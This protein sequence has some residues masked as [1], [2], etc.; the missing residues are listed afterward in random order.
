MMDKI[1]IEKNI[2]DL[3]KKIMDVWAK[4]HENNIY[5]HDIQFVIREIKDADQ[6]VSD[7][8][9]L[10]NH[11]IYVDSIVLVDKIDSIQSEITWVDMQLCKVTKTNVLFLVKLIFG[12]DDEQEIKFHGGLMNILPLSLSEIKQ[13]M[14]EETQKVLSMGRVMCP[15]HISNNVSYLKLKLKQFA[16]QDSP[17][18]RERKRYDVFCKKKYE[19]IDDLAK[20]IYKYRNTLSW[21]DLLLYYT[22]EIETIIIVE[23]LLSDKKGTP[24]FHCS[25][26]KP[27]NVNNDTKFDPN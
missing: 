27:L 1:N 14:L 2:N 10:K 24:S 25:I 15:D 4:Y 6:T 12:K 7:I 20:E 11:R 17:V 26:R 13:R 21:I 3:S 9:Y 23:I 5:S 8:D 18:E 16:L 19:D 22:S